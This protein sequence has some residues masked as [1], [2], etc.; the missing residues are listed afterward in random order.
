MVFIKTGEVIV[1]RASSQGDL[2]RY[3][4]KNSWNYKAFDFLE[5]KWFFAQ[6]KEAL[7][8]AVF[9][10]ERLQFEYE[11]NQWSIVDINLK[12]FGAMILTPWHED[13]ATGEVL[14]R[15][16]PHAKL[17]EAC[18]VHAQL[19]ESFMGLKFFAPYQDMIEERWCPLDHFI[20]R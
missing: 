9:R 16:A 8:P 2:L 17:L 6:T 12:Q 20:C 11:Q 7:L 3:L 18:W 14:D 13:F 5:A 4:Q 15:R 10:L 19:M 1:A